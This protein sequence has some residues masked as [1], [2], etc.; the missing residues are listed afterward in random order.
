[1]V[2]F[3]VSC[4]ASR[5]FCNVFPCAS[6]L[7]MLLSVMHVMLLCEKIVSSR[8]LLAMLNRIRRMAIV[9]PLIEIKFR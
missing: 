2:I 7:G 9:P 3:W 5:R 6:L 4:T 1:M 8:F